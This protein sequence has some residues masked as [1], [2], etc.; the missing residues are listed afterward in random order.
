M[1]D[2]ARRPSTGSYAS[3]GSLK[4]RASTGATGAPR[5]RHEM[6]M[7]RALGGGGGT[8][9]RR[10]SKELPAL[11][12]A[13]AVPRRRSSVG[14]LESGRRSSLE[15]RR[16]STGEVADMMDKPAVAPMRTAW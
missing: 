2:D 12:A 5:R 14:S 1:Q 6:E 13:A 8:P 11:S 3:T 16:T 7:E 10:S 4:R 9:V 15:S